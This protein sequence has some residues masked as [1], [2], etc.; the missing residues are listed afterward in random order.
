[1]AARDA[2]W[3]ES[4]A[5]LKEVQPEPAERHPG[6]PEGHELKSTAGGL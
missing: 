6:L 4:L 1:M 2:P 3:T 5:E